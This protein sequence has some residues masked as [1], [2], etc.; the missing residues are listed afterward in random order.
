M[1]RISSKATFYYKRVFPIIW[2]GFLALFV[3]VGLIGALTSSQIPQLLFVIVPAAM[4]VFGYFIMKKLVFDLVDEVLD[5]DDALIIRNGAQEERI[6]LADIVN[7]SY[8]ALTNPP[9]VTLSLRKAGAFGS[10]VSF[11]APLRFM[12]FST[13]PIVDELIERIDAKRRADAGRGW[14]GGGAAQ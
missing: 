9:R 11:C 14:P 5:A 2:F 1:R 6:P 4:A 10:K 13:S 8:A 3:A 7:V 12:P